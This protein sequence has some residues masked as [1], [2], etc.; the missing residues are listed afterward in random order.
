ML[1]FLK[2]AKIK[3]ILKKF[4][5]IAEAMVKPQFYLFCIKL[6]VQKSIFSLATEIC[7]LVYSRS[8]FAKSSSKCLGSMGSSRKL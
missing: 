8:T 7:F 2:I 1:T 3:K 6:H 5:S 4:T